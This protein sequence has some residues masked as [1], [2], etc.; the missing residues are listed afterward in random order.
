MASG[1]CARPGVGEK[2]KQFRKPAR[3]FGFQG[4]TAMR[5][6]LL[7]SRIVASKPA[8]TRP[9]SDLHAACDRDVT[10]HDFLES[11]TST[12]RRTT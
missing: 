9:C 10:H 6:G 3:A 11:P 7:M 4:R 12:P 2:A 1:H 8:P 5:F